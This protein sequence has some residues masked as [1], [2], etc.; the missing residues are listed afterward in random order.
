MIELPEAVVIAK[1]ITDT[2]KGKPIIIEDATRD[3]RVQYPDEAKREGRVIGWTV[4][5]GHYY[6]L[7]SDCR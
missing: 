3:P 2:L 1:Q 7:R 4:S 5:I 6:R